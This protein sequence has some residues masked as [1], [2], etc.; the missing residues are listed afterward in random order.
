[1]LALLATFYNLSP[2]LRATLFWSIGRNH[3]LPPAFS[4]KIGSALLAEIRRH[5]LSPFFYLQIMRQ[6]GQKTLPSPWLELL[7]HDYCFSLQKSL[8]QEHEALLVLQALAAAGIEVILLKGADLHLRLYDD[9]A[10][11]PMADLDL[12]IPRA[13]LAKARAAL[14]RLGYGLSPDSLD[15]R[16]GFREH[17]RAGLHFK[18]TKEASLMVDLHWQIEAVANFYRLPYA[19]LRRQ[20]LPMDYQGVPV[21]VLSP[22]HLLIHLCL[23]NYDELDQALRIVDLG[24]ALQRLPLDWRLFLEE[25]DRLGCQAPLYLLLGEL[26]RLFPRTVPAEVLTSLGNYHPSYFEKIALN[27]RLNPLV[28]LF[29]PLYH[30]RQ[31]G[32]WVRYFAALF[33]PQPD[34]LAAV[35]GQRAREAYFRQVLGCLVPSLTKGNSE[36]NVEIIA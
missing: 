13:A 18:K 7:K 8:R 1:M 12:M 36:I 26:A 27:Q 9:P 10:I 15:P 25:A 21:K 32:D 33:W 22:E 34:Y 24:L 4:A 16:P 5:R 2:P 19:S 6:G 20:A 23:H 11:R 14:G 17:F 31:A 28:R 35:Y 30:H 3:S 29:A